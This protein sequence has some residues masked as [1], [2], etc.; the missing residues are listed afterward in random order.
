MSFSIRN[1]GA[2]RG[3]RATSREPRASAHG[4]EG[5]SMSTE[6]SIATAAPPGAANRQVNRVQ[7]RARGNGVKTVR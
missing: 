1:T 5:V 7:F 6:Y 2:P 3:S 4:P